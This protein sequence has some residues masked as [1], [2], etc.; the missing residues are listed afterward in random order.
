MAK[1]GF[2]NARFIED[3]LQ[4]GDGYVLNFSDK[5]FARFFAEELEID[6][7]DLRYH[8]KGRSKANRMRAFLEVS[9]A[10]TVV[11]ALN[12]LRQYRQAMYEQFD[13]QEDIKNEEGRFQ[14]LMLELDGR[15][16]ATAPSP[17]TMRAKILNLAADYRALAAMANAQ[18]RGYAFE[19]FLRDLF[20]ASGLEARQAFRLVGEQIDGSIANG[21]DIYLIEAKWQDGRIGA[22]P[23][24]VLQGKLGQKAAWARGLFI[25]YSGFTED[26]LEAFGR[27]NR[28]LCMDG[29]DIHESLE[30]ELPIKSII[31]AKVRRAAE[32]GLPFVRVRDLIL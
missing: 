27:A 32:T 19:T 24:H 30:R 5:T 9:D 13:K 23:L 2:L 7:D 12:A 28:V 1:L 6:I 14:Q 22:G 11:R 4:M 25:S 8:A 31:D 21:S 26:G 18:A 15:A 29:L 10:A 16:P 20:D 17:S 3:L